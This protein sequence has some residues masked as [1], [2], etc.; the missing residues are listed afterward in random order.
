MPNITTNH[1]ITYT[2]ILLTGIQIK[3]VTG[4]EYF[5]SLKFM[6]QMQSAQLSEAINSKKIQEL[7]LYFKN[8]RLLSSSWSR[9]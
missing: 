8:L 3:V 7:N 6:A 1:S 2:N 9:A 5:F 4:H